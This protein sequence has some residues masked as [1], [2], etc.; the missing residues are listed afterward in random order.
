MFTLKKI[1]LFF[2]NL[3]FFI[4]KNVLFLVF[5]F[6]RSLSGKP[7]QSYTNHMFKSNSRIPDV[8]IYLE[9]CVMRQL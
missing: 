5:M 3:D 4:F 6:I 8:S 2:K 9:F 7:F 1:F